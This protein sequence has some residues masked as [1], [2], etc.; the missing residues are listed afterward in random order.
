MPFTAYIIPSAP[1]FFLVIANLKQHKSWSYWSPQRSWCCVV[2]LYHFDKF[3]NDGVFAFKTLCSYWVL[4]SK[5]N[6]SS[7]QFI[8][9]KYC[10]YP[11]FEEFYPHFEELRLGF[12]ESI[13]ITSSKPLM[14]YFWRYYS[15]LIIN[16][17][18][19]IFPYWRCQCR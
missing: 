15:K 2:M 9:S 1:L 7:I 19:L 11:H 8:T 18:C 3:L 14:P 13:K 16:S 17:F 5:A 12:F 4:T 6:R 10:I